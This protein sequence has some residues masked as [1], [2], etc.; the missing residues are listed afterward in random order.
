MGGGDNKFLPHGYFVSSL[1]QHSSGSYHLEAGWASLG[2]Q[3]Q[4]FR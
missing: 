3:I 2:H 1:G 4:L